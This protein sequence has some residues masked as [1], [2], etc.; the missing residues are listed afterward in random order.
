MPSIRISKRSVDALPIPVSGDAYHWDET[1]KG[2]GVRV[3]PR[4]VRSYVIQYR[5][6]GR[7][8]R[9]MTLGMHGS[10]WTPEKARIEAER[11]L[12]VVKQGTDPAEEAKRRVTDARN[13]AFSDYVN[14]FADRC[15]KEEWPDS[16]WEAKRTLERH[17]VPH[18][19]RRAVTEVT[20]Q[21]VRAVI[22]P[23]REKRALAR[24][25]WAVLSRL[26]SWAVEE[27]DLP[28]AANPMLGLKPPPKPKDR[29]RILN[30]DELI[31]VWRASFELNDPFGPYV[32]LLIATLQRRC[33]VSDADWKEFDRERLVW[34]NP[35]RIKNDAHH[36]LPLNSVAIAEL[37]SLGWRER[38]L[39]FSTTGKTPISGFSRM[40]RQLDR[41]M[42][43]ILQELAAKHAAASYQKPELVALEPWTLHDLRRTGSSMLQRLG[44]PIEVADKCL[45]HKFGE[46]AKG[47]RKPYFVWKYEPEKRQAMDRWGEYLSNL[48]RSSKGT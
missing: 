4:G 12:F 22:E 3:T 31:A 38:G 43:P 14:R 25:V 48:I 2:F 33:D 1:L 20:A 15:L 41:H 46:E 30:E 39:L 40:K 32:R 8:A 37:E 6:K 42:L 23:I 18:L 5:L 47:S 34:I 7:P 17:V 10:P 11:L 19:K 26:L 13:L 27:Q 35:G 21:D 36:L 29:N 45:S 44:I 9:R 16:W 28:P 24:K